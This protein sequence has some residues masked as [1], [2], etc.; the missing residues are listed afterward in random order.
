MNPWVN[1]VFDTPDRFDVLLQ[2][3]RIVTP[4]D[5]KSNILPFTGADSLENAMPRGLNA[6]VSEMVAK[7]ED[8]SLIMF[9]CKGSAPFD[10][11]MIAK[12]EQPGG[13]VVR[14]A[15][16]F[17][18]KHSEVSGAPDTTA[19]NMASKYT[20]VAKPLLAHFNNGDVAST[21]KDSIAGMTIAPPFLVTNRGVPKERYGV[22]YITDKKL[23]IGGLSR[24]AFDSMDD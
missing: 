5:S 20:K 16:L 4:D 19:K 24:A 22:E 13:N 21:E 11:V 9:R 12:Y 17:D 14:R 15:A 23:C 18:S 6:Q 8:N 1:T 10:Y 7:M 3:V 2:S